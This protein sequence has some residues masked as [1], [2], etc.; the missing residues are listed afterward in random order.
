MQI[1]PYGYLLPFYTYQQKVPLG[2]QLKISN[3]QCTFIAAMKLK[4]ACSLEEK[5]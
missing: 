1:C 2:K 4:D 5:L 3:G